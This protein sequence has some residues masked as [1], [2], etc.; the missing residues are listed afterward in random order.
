MSKM[1]TGKTFDKISETEEKSY[2]KDKSLSQ[3]L[4]EKTIK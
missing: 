2:E 1:W 4:R 3:M